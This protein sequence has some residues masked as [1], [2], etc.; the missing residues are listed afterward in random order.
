[1][2]MTSFVSGCSAQ[3]IS[4]SN[5]QADIQ[6]AEQIFAPLR[7]HSFFGHFIAFYICMLVETWPDGGAKGIVWFSQQTTNGAKT[8]LR[9]S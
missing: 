1:M 8:L 9:W 5:G 7:T 6:F 3:K 2:K 4:T